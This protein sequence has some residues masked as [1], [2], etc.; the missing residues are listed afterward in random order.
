MVTAAMVL[1]ARQFGLVAQGYAAA[2]KAGLDD[3]TA[4]V[5]VMSLSGQSFE[6]G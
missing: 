6:R 2:T 1:L 4:D 3:W 5:S